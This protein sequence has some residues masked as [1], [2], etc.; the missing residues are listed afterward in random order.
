MKDDI[1]I[2]IIV[3]VYKTEK[4]LERCLNSIINQ[5]YKNIEIILVDDGS[6]DNCPDICD[7]YQKK[8]KRIKI[9]HKNNEG[10]SD[11][12]NKG[13]ELATGKYILFVDSDDEIILTAV[14]ELVDIIRKNHPDLICFNCKEVDEE[15]KAEIKNHFY[16]NSCTKQVTEMTYEEAIADN[17]NRKNIRYEAGSKLYSIEVIKKHPFPKGMLAED[18]AVFYKYLSSAKKIIHY[19]NQLYIY[20]RR[21]DS[22]MGV[23]N[24]KLY[25]DVYK[26]EILYFEEIKKLNLNIKDRKKAEDNYFK[27]LIK[28]YSKINKKSHKEIINEIEYRISK[29][30]F[31]NLKFIQKILFI[32]YKI[33]KEIPVYIL[34][35]FY[36]KL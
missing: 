2:S 1:Y 33:N 30:K 27:T 29:V 7:N 21:K 3:P 24:E 19:D 11:A 5:T 10:L 18:F 12:R 31:L 17:I 35:K 23:K 9:I 36:K 34:N 15:S 4:Y 20:Y 14:E 32:L 26:T 16:S 25:I 28:T 6:P 13:I 8:D 22:I